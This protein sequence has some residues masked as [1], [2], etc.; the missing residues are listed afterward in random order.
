MR[1]QG[2]GNRLN[3]EGRKVNAAIVDLLSGRSIGSAGRAALNNRKE[4]L[5]RTCWAPKGEGKPVERKE[6][7]GN[8]R[9]NIK[10]EGN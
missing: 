3:W 8:C 10:D 9:E 6:N 4:I 7:S 5:K 2:K 1:N